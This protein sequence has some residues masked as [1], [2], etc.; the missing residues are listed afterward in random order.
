MRQI[1]NPVERRDFFCEDKIL[2]LYRYRTVQ[3]ALL[4]LEN[5]SFYF[6]K[7]EELNDPLEGYLKI[8]LQGDKPAWEGLLKNFVCSLFYNLQT[9]LLMVR[10]F[11]GGQ[12]NYLHDFQNRIVITNLRHFENSPLN[13][14]FKELAE[15]FLRDIEVKKVINFYGDENIKC[16][17]R[18]LEFILRTV[19]DAAC[20]LC[21]KK[22]KSLGLI[23]SDFD[24]TFFDVA[25]E[26]SFSKLKSLNNAERKRQIDDIE[27]LNL[28]AM[29]SGLLGLKLNRRNVTDLNYELKQKILQ[30]KIFFP[31]IYAEQLKEIMYPNGYVVCFSE[32]PTNSAMW[33]N[34]AD[35]HRGI[36]FIYETETL[37][38]R[39]FINFATKSLEVK[40][41]KYSAQFIERNFFNTLK[42]LDFLR[43]D[44]WLT[45]KNGVKSCKLDEIEATGEY[46]DVYHEKFYR[47]TADWY[48]EREYRIFLPDEFHRYA[49][50][51]SRHL[52]YDLSL[53]K[54]IIF[55]LPRLTKPTYG[56]FLSLASCGHGENAPMELKPTARA[57]L[58]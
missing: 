17:G 45:G 8:F 21:V 30:L 53:L 55:G 20:H 46:D 15:S 12:N 35:N 47:K 43:A 9:Y 38:G 3:S 13:Q 51:F 56:K 22:C 23:Q 1:L 39:D 49:D 31:R 37:D 41:I 48:H 33:G 52:R 28:D 18:E 40:Q 6:A 58:T 19:A 34:Y 54:G 24:E 29:E 57:R 7:P 5:G 11:G 16:Y 25:Y 4:E 36:C 10:N 2:K 42:H 27:N 50:K 14:I 32:T 26:I 44:D